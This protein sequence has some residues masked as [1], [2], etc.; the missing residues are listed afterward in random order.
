MNEESLHRQEVVLAM[1]ESLRSIVS[2]EDPAYPVI[3]ENSV[4]T[5][6]EG[7]ARG[8][9]CRV[10]FLRLLEL[11]YDRFCG[12]G[13][14]TTVGKDLLLGKFETIREVVDAHMERRLPSKND[15]DWVPREHR[16]RCSPG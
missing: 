7:W 16:P 15:K 1:Q 5:E 10:N 14:G 11:L 4:F 9:Q 13:L 3:S 2:P 12:L 8:S 6:F